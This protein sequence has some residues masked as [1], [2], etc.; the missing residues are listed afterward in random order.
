M[1]L[2]SGGYEDENLKGNSELWRVRVGRAVFTGYETGTIYCNGAHEPEL[3]FVYDRI[4][5][6]LE[7]RVRDRSRDRAVQ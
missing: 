6:L 7:N 2:R 4:D 1:L 5:D 3:Q